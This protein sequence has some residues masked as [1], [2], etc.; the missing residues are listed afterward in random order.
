MFAATPP[1]SCCRTSLEGKGMP[2]EG[3]G[4][5]SGGKA[6]ASSDSNEERGESGSRILPCCGRY[7]A[8]FPLFLHEID[9]VLLPIL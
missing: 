8:L 3:H 1:S 4:R 5:M 6:G 9:R 2:T 7:S